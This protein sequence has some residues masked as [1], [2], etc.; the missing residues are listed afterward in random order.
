MYVYIYISVLCILKLYNYEILFLKA[1]D[2]YV[3]K[4][5]CVS[6]VFTYKKRREEKTQMK[7]RLSFKRSMDSNWYLAN[8]V[9]RGFV[10][11]GICF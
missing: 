6:V 8:R 9:Q 1:S 10:V 5:V 2:M 11:E 3:H 4:Q 7:L